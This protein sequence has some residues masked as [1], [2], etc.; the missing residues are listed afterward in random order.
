MQPFIYRAAI[1][2]WFDTGTLQIATYQESFHEVLISQHQIGW[3]HLF[4]GYWSI[5]WEELHNTY[6]PLHSTE[7]IWTEAMVETSLTLII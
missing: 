1:T 2:E 3:H 7:F 4:M 5:K 6:T